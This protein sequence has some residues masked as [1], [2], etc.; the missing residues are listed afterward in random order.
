MGLPQQQSNKLPSADRHHVWSDSARQHENKNW[1]AWLGVHA[2]E[3]EYLAIGMFWSSWSGELRLWGY[4]NLRK[5][6]ILA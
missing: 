2:K 3:G 6:V 1:N 4:V 5:I